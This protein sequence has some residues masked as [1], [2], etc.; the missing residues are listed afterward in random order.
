MFNITTRLTMKEI[1]TKTQ[2]DASSLQG[3]A[4]KTI[5]DGLQG[6]GENGMP[7]QSF[8]CNFSQ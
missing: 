6:Y 4:V 3:I 8:I 7:A 1:V 2:W 5:H